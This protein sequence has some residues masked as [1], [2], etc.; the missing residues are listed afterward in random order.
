MR[1]SARPAVAGASVAC[2]SRLH[3]FSPE[4]DDSD[5]EQRQA[6]IDDYYGRHLPLLACDMPPALAWLA[7]V[8]NLHDAQASDFNCTDVEVELRLL[9]GDLE[10]GYEWVSLKYSD[11]AV[12][13]EL[14][15]SLLL[16]HDAEVLYHEVDRGADGRWEHRLSMWP[17]GEV[18]IR[19]SDVEV[20]RTPARPEDRDGGAAG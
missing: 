12:E 7:K 18:V 5:P 1:V 17:R 15:E 9:L 2:V 11:A 19:F 10:A 20:S 8:A 6:V 13:P 16:D 14:A 3:W 4:W